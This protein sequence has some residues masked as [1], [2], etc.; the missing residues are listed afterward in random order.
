MS[1]IVNTNFKAKMVLNLLRAKTLLR[2]PVRTLSGFH[3]FRNPGARL[4]ESSVFLQTGTQIT[5]LPLVV[6]KV[7]NIFELYKRLGIQHTTSELQPTE[8]EQDKFVLTFP[9]EI[10][11]EEREII[12]GFNRCF[13]SSSIF[14]LLETIPREEV[15]PLVAIHALRKIIDLENNFEYRNPGATRETIRGNKRSQDTFLRMA[16]MTMLLEIVCNSRQPRVILDGLNTVMRDQF[17][18]NLATYKERLLEELMICVTEGVFS[19][20]EVCRAINILSMFYEDRKRCLEMADKLW[21][22]IV[23]Q[24]KQINSSESIVAVFTALP[25]LNKSRRIVMKILEKKTLENWDKFETGDII[26]ILRVLVEIKY[27][28]ISPSFLGMVSEWLALN[29]HQ[30]KEG[31]LMAIV[32]SLLQLNY[33]DNKLITSLEKVIKHRGCQITEVDLV[34]TICDYCHHFRIRSPIVLE[35]AS[36]YLV[37]HVTKLSIPQIYSIARI[38]GYLDFHPTTGFKFWLELESLL[39]QKFIQFKPREIIE[40]LVSFLYI[41]KYPLNF[42]GKLF[43]PFFLDRLHNQP[44]DEVGISRLQLKLFDAG[45]KLECRGYGGPY[46]PKDTSIRALDIDNRIRRMSKLLFDP[47]GKILGDYSR[48]GTR[49]CL[50]SLPLHPAFIVDLMIY[51]TRS[52]SLLRFGFKTENSSNIAVLIHLPEHYD[53]RGVNLLGSQAMRIR[54]LETMGFR[55]MRVDYLKL[56]QLLHQPTQMKEYLKEQYTAVVKSKNEK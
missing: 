38:F 26:E 34:T 14:R 53:R 30:V 23:D 3:G 54:H 35:G 4:G 8:S 5:E 28:R 49:V 18:A 48:I 25:S 20:L 47:L 27:D 52:E 33:T 51:P 2:G 12:D 44:Q 50:S 1:V 13:T 55:V 16:F 45:M 11:E 15:T 43:T 40:L 56:S 17:P 39:E 29:I 46:L 6:R 10:G 32:Y 9:P 24:S 7:N 22:G 19:V 41:E 31:E 21:F 36:E 42:T 37:Y